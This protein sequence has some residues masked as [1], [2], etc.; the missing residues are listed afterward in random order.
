MDCSPPCSSVHGISQARILEWVAIFFSRGSSSPRDQ[1]WISWITGG[2]FTNW[3]TRETHTNAWKKKGKIEI[4]V[5]QSCPTLSDPLDCSLPG[6]SVYG[7]FQ[8]KVL[9]W[10]ATSFSRGS[11]RPRDQTRVSHTVDRHFTKWAT[12]EV[13][14]QWIFTEAKAKDMS[15]WQTISGLSKK[16]PG[17]RFLTMEM[18]LIYASS[19]RDLKKTKSKIH[20]RFIT[21]KLCV[22]WEW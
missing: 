7:I 16:A 8:A 14:I 9:E 12:R 18:P 21:I 3:A 10:V 15:S 13:P 4:K 6:S 19:N 1:I 20:I 2:F 17:F 5:A 11:S 22:G